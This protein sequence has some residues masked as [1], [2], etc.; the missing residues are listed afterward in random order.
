M[1]FNFNGQRTNGRV[2]CE[3]ERVLWLPFLFFYFMLN[4]CLIHGGYSVFLNQ[5]PMKCFICRVE[6]Q[7]HL[8]RTEIKWGKIV[9]AAYDSS[10]NCGPQ[11]TIIVWYFEFKTLIDIE[12]LAHSNRGK[13]WMAKEKECRKIISN[14]NDQKCPLFSSLGVKYCHLR[15]AMYIIRAMA[16]FVCQNYAS[17]FVHLLPAGHCNNNNID[18]F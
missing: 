1:Y 5:I 6:N 18:V 4:Q 11:L 2:H 7:I 9:I 3:T 12:S 10:S 14:G 8:I 17:Q 16:I 15:S 13:V